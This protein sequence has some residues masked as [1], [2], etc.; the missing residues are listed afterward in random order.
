LP[1]TAE[2]RERFANE[3]VEDILLVVT[4]SGRIPAWP[5]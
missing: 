4:Y 2:N 1:N 5:V 3:Q